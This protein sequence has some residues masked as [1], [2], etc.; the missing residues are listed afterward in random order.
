VRYEATGWREVIDFRSPEAVRLFPKGTGTR[1]RVSKSE[2]PA[3]LLT[4]A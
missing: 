2:T 3:A 4:I 1:R